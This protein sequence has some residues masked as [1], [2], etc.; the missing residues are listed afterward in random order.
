MVSRADA[1]HGKKFKCLETT[2]QPVV[3][4]CQF[5][6][7]YVPPRLG[8]LLS[9]PIFSMA[10]T[11]RLRDGEGLKMATRGGVNGSLKFLLKYL[12]TVPKSHPSPQN[13][14]TSKWDAHEPSSG[15]MFSVMTD[16]HSGA[17]KPARNWAQLRNT[18][19]PKIGLLTPT[20]VKKEPKTK[21]P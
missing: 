14:Q 6:C 12:A 18:Q 10:A 5:A 11:M 7:I 19:N 8:P 1:S 4:F 2:N 16:E 3:R 9:F 20:E 21:S 17:L 13:R 15:W